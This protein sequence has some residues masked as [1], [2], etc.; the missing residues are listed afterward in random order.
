MADFAV[1]NSKGKQD[2]IGDLIDATQNER[3]VN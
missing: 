2:A 3:G 1:S